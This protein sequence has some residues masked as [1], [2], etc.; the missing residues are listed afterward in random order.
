[1]GGVV[2]AGVGEL[3]QGVGQPGRGEDLSR[4]G[5]DRSSRAFASRT[6]DM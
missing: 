6:S 5:V 1:V 3:V 2:T 4:P